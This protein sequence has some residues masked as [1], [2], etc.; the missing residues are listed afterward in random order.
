[1]SILDKLHKAAVV[2]IAV[3][4]V[5]SAFNLAIVV[6]NTVVRARELRKA[7]MIE[8]Q[9]QNQNKQASDAKSIH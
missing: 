9:N 8:I 4:S 2:S 6:R 3:I 7:K 1:M 5:Y